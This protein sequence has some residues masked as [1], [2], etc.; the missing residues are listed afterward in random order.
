MPKIDAHAHL[1]GYGLDEAALVSLLGRHAMRWISICWY[2]NEAAFARQAALGRR[3][4]T[5][6]PGRFSWITT[7]PL[8]G[9][10]RASWTERAIN[11]VEEGLA[12]GAVGVK[13]W[14]NVGMELKDADGRHVMIDDPRFDPVLERV[15]A[16]GLTLAAHIGEPRNAWLPLVEM[17]VAG[18]R[19]YFAAH[20]EYHA[21][22]RPEIP[23]YWEQVASRDRMLERHP[24]LRVVGCHLGSL[25]FDVRELAKRLDRFPSFAVDLSARACHLKVQR[26]D[27]VR[28]FFEAYQD[29]ILYG[30]D[31]VLGEEGVEAAD[32]RASLGRAEAHYLADYR[33]FAGRDTVEAPDV[34]PGARCEALGLRDAVLEKL[35]RTNALAW[36]P[37]IGGT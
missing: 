22:N 23:G 7:F 21:I 18:D 9:F 28:E 27:V 11:A 10:S 2:E 20:P 31:T 14:K 5:T 8:S 37:M 17:T 35:F 1:A 24:D 6:H 25:E 34:G 19:A 29:R 15:R 33:Y 32:V 4:S 13:V 26:S 36:Y 30:T 3:F 12:S 16:S